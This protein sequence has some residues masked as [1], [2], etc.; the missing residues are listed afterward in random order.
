[1]WGDLFPHAYPSSVSFCHVP[2]IKCA[3]P[4]D[5]G[6]KSVIIYKYKKQLFCICAATSVGDFEGNLEIPLIHRTDR[7]RQ[8]LL[9]GQVCILP[10]KKINV[11][12]RQFRTGTVTRLRRMTAY[13]PCAQT[14]L[15]NRSC[16]SPFSLVPRSAGDLYQ[17]FAG[18]YG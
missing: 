1:M 11:L 7:G 17:L 3:K 2:S 8:T 18:R 6:E 13:A 15:S 16:N 9:R 4:I 14:C 5:N 12:D 10:D